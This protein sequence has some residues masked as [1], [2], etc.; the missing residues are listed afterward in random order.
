MNVAE[1]GF[2]PASENPFASEYVDSVPYLFVTENRQHHLS[3]LAAL[4]YHAAITGPRGTGKTTLLDQTA[5]WLARESADPVSRVCISRCHDQ[6]TRVVTDLVDQKRDGCILLIDGM[7]RLSLANRYRL[8]TS[9]RS[10]RGGLLVTRHRRGI[11]PTWMRCAGSSLVL[12]HVLDHLIEDLDSQLRREAH[13][14]LRGNG[15]N[16]RDVLRYLYDQF[17]AGRGAPRS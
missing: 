17:A 14:R 4:D 12:N 9:R 15:G 1:T 3:R 16:V 5:R 7:E 11:L 10:G 8:L 13:E 2:L 6:H